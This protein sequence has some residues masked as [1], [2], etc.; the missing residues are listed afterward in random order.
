MMLTILAA[1]VALAAV[2]AVFFAALG[3]S[4]LREDQELGHLP[5]D[6]ATPPPLPHEPNRLPEPV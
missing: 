3:R 2:T 5:A 4:A 1:W 6:A